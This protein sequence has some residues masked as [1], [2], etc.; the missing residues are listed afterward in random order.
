[1]KQPDLCHHHAHPH[2]HA[3]WL[4]RLDALGSAAALICALHCALLPM[5]VV[6]LPLAAVQVLGNHFYEQFFVAGALVFGALVLGSG[7]S[8]ASKRS[9]IG[10]FAAGGVLLLLG[11]NAHEHMI[12]HAIL[13]TL[14]GLSLGAAHAL[15]RHSARTWLDARAIW[16]GRRVQVVRSEVID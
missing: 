11:L 10:L 14:G 6:A 5:A 13:M 9:V 8:A 7:L 16:A 15:N 3:R 4:P 1:M 12:L 2:R